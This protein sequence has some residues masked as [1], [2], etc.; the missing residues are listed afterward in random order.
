MVQRP[1]G[2]EQQD[3]DLGSKVGG[4]HG[5]DEDGAET[6]DDGEKLLMVDS[7]AART[8]FK[9]GEL[10]PV[11]DGETVGLRTITGQTI[12]NYGSQKPSIVM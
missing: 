6:L 4:Q 9:V 10:A 11:Q 2:I 5:D 12:K 7:G 8:V 3:P 1:L